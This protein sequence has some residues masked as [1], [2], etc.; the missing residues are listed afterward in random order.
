M[1]HRGITPGRMAFVWE[2][3]GTGANNP[4]HSALLPRGESQ[5]NPHRHHPI[6]VAFERQLIKESMHLPLGCLQGGPEPYTPRHRLA[7]LQRR[8]R[9][10]A[11]FPKILQ[12]TQGGLDRREI[13]VDL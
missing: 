9:Q 13:L 12:L 6:R 7:A 2:L 3:T 10:E 8:V 1:N 4:R 11:R 5:A